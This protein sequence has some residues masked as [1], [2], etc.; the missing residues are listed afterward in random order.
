MKNKICY[1]KKK[2]ER[3]W[4]K[5]KEVFTVHIAYTY[6]TSPRCMKVESEIQKGWIIRLMPH[7]VAKPRQAMNVDRE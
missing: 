3:E 1:Q 5:E 6:G 2:R 7:W 4:I